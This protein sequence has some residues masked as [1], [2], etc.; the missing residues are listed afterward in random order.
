MRSLYINT[1]TFLLILLF[2]SLSFFST[3]LILTDIHRPEYYVSLW[4]L[5]L[6]HAILVIM[7]GFLYPSSWKNKCFLTIIILFSIR[8][9]L[10]PLLMRLG[11]YNGIF[12]LLN[13]SNVNRAICL[14]L[15]ETLFVVLY[16]SYMTQHVYRVRPLEIGAEKNIIAD[17]LFIVSLFFG[18]CIYIFK[19]GFF[20]GFVTIFQL[21]KIRFVETDE[22]VLGPFFTVFSVL[23][24][25]TYIFCSLYLLNRINRMKNNLARS[26]LNLAIVCIPLLFMN[27]GDAFTLI[28]MASLAITS[29]RMGGVSERQLYIVGGTLFLVVVLLLFWLI[30][31]GYY[32]GIFNV[33]SINLQAYF[34]G[35]GNFAGYFN[36][37]EHGKL[38]S[39]FY[40][41]YFAIPFRN[42]LFGIQGDNRLVMLYTKDNNAGSQ[43]IP[44]FIQLFY[45]VGFLAPLF[46]LIII[47]YA[48]KCYKSFLIRDNV[49]SCFLNVITWI[50][51][52][53]T[54]VMYN[55]TILM[56]RVLST[57]IYL[58][59]ISRILSNNKGARFY[60]VTD[61][62]YEKT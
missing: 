33:L 53:L 47:K 60:N 32:K 44:C 50:Y 42:T 9:V 56:T 30:N 5:P 41:V 37:G 6:F 58:Y 21:D 17:I 3:F 29:F 40:D 18:I 55:F 57:I 10:T 12:K 8:N 25:L 7:A 51:L 43:I 27:G 31:D 19:R 52:V 15:F 61:R 26:W 24:P 14:M 23:F 1:K 34:P 20:S 59:V 4:M 36:I 48:F 49:Y 35:A 2:L 54:P 22:K 16:S 62:V 11:G 28:C 39:L 13:V 46:E 45:Y 38:S